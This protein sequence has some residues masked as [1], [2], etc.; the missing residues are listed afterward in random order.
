V[1]EVPREP[2]GRHAA[3]PELAL[4]H[5]TI[6]ESLGERSRPG[7]HVE[8][9]FGLITICVLNTVI[10]SGKTVSGQTKGRGKL[11]AGSMR[12]GKSFTRSSACEPK[13]SHHQ[14]VT[15]Y[16]RLYTSATPPVLRDGAF[17]DTIR[18]RRHKLRGPIGQPEPPKF[19]TDETGFA[20]ECPMIV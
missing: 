16:R 6:A 15:L 4:E 10:P 5:V 13:P 7:A 12:S 8:S 2:D 11:A 9:G 3:A 20:I 18:E 17:F 1:A 14:K 19:T